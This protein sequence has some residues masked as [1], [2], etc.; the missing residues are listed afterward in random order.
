MCGFYMQESDTDGNYSNYSAKCG[1]QKH[2][3]DMAT[4]LRTVVVLFVLYDNGTF[5]WDIARVENIS[6][7]TI[8]YFL[9][10]QDWQQEPL[11]C[12]IFSC[13]SEKDST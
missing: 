6:G 9:C 4:A 2:S 3:S 13:T 12:A 8:M 1:I 7:Q 11:G 5:N 10:C